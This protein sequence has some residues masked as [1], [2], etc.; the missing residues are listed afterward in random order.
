MAASDFLKSM[1]GQGYKG[2][3]P[4]APDEKKEGVES[5]D[6]S[7]VSRML[8]LTE[9]ELKAFEGAAPG[10]DVACEVHGRL[11]KD[12]NFHVMSVE[13]M[14]SESYEGENEMA[15]QV[16]QKVMPQIVPSPS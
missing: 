15:G 7:S 10:E 13:P 3:L 14:D 11:E 8:T 5:G 1:R 2:S 12:G 6:D 9:D 16:A 4:E